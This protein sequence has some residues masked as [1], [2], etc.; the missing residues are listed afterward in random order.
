M[1]QGGELRVTR[2]GRAVATLRGARAERFLAEVTAGEAQVV[3]ARSTGNQ[4]R[5][6]E[7]TARDH[8][9]SPNRR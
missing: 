7:R 3:L 5:G 2:D 1:R 4:R 8:P 9:R 6:N